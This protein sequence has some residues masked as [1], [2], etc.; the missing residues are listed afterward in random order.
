MKSGIEELIELSESPEMS[1][2]ERFG[3]HENGSVDLER[4]M[5]AMAEPNDERTIYEIAEGIE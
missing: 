3:Q 1:L 4:I 5:K 2:R